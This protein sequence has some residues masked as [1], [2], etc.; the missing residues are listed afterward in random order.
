MRKELSHFKSKYC[1]P[2]KQINKHASCCNRFVHAFSCKPVS[3]QSRKQQ[4]ADETLGR[5]VNGFHGHRRDE[6]K[7]THHH[8]SL[9]PVTIIHPAGYLFYPFFSPI[10]TASNNPGI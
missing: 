6:R 3:Q 9:F 1:V 5:D 2:I 7:I 4:L 8:L 10:L